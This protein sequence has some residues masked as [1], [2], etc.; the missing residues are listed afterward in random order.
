MDV[1]ELL[2]YVPVK[3]H[4]P[5]RHRNTE[6]SSVTYS[7][8]MSVSSHD[9]GDIYHCTINLTVPNEMFSLFSDTSVDIFPPEF[10]FAWTSSPLNVE[11]EFNFC[12]MIIIALGN[13]FAFWFGIGFHTG[14]KLN[15]NSHYRK[16]FH[17][18][19]AF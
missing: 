19:N 3:R 2:C 6:Y 5:V 13:I 7:T 16:D 1:I 10:N 8:V 4:R 11:C 14:L 12:V 18:V 17:I 15:I 9:N